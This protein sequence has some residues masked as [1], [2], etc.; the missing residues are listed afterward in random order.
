MVHGFLNLAIFGTGSFRFGSKSKLCFIFQH[1]LYL[2]TILINQITVWKIKVDILYLVHNL[3][4]NDLEPNNGLTKKNKR[5]I[6]EEEKKDDGKKKNRRRRS[7]EEIRWNWSANLEHLNKM[8]SLMG[9]FH[10][11]APTVNILVLCYVYKN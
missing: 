10:F 9:F 6:V 7:R 8:A 1:P 4:P 3:E 11:V 5:R 2:Y